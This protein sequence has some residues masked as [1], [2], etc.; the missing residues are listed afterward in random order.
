[1]NRKRKHK[2]HRFVSFTTAL[3]RNLLSFF[4][5]QYGLLFLRNL[6]VFKQDL[7]ELDFK[8]KWSERRKEEDKNHECRMIFSRNWPM[9]EENKGRDYREFISR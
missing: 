7:G 6:E 5:D 9:T 3:L 8:E 2:S 4:R 1:M